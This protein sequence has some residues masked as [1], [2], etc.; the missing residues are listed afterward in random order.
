MVGPVLYVLECNLDNHMVFVITFY[1]I[2]IEGSWGKMGKN[3][4]RKW[5][6]P[7]LLAYYVFFLI[8]LHL[9]R[10]GAKLEESSL[11]PI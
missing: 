9:N 11:A 5:I 8:G 7:L 2:L 6:I 1:Y 4:L 10:R 3:L